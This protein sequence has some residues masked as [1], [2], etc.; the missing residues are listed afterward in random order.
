[1]TPELLAMLG[2]GVSGFVMKLIGAQ[3]DNQARQFERMISYQQGADSSADAAA[4]RSAGVIVRRFLVVA[5]VFAIVIAPFVFAWTDVGVS[6][7]RETNGFLGLFKTLKWET[8]QGFVILPEI[9]QTAL[10]IVGFYF[11]SSQIK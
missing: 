2:G 6:V 9:R 11:G 4:K 8:V 7:A 1:M 10:A 3:M 5:T